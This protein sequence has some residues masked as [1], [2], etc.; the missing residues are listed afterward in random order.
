MNTL[1]DFVRES[2]RIEGIIRDPTKRELDATQAFLTLERLTVR[3]VCALVNVYAPG[4]ELREHVGMNVRVGAHVPP[5]GG[6]I[7]RDWLTD[8]LACVNA[9]KLSAFAAHV[10]YE[11]LH[12][13]M[14]GNGRSGRAIW[15]W[16]RGGHAPLGFLHAFYYETLDAKHRSPVEH[17]EET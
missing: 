1:Q 8:L 16:M 3:D 7:M 5:R 17:G 12:P 6:P 11:T 2:N 15:L 14:D 13:F 9:S 4:A 10:E